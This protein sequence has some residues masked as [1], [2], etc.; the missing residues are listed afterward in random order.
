MIKKSFSTQTYIYFVVVVV[1][2][3]VETQILHDTV[4]FTL[5]HAVVISS[6]VNTIVNHPGALR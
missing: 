2:R 4:G 6:A 5:N 1:A 3:F